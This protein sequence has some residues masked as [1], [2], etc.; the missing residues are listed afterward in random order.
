MLK[1]TL[2]R[3]LYGVLTLLIIITITFF[4]L[5]I[6]PGSPFNDEKLTA[7]QIAILN[8]KYGLSD[9][10]PMQY[11]RYIK[12]IVTKFDF[13]KSFKYDNQDV[14]RKLIVPRLPRTIKVGLFA[15]AIGITV[16]IILGSLA[17]L[18]RGNF[19]DNILIVLAVLGSSIPSFVFAMVLQYTFAVKIPIFPVLYD[20]TKIISIVLPAI[21]LSVSTISTLTRF[22]RTELVEVLNSDYILLAR[23][24]GLTNAQV[25]FKHALRNALIPVITIVGPMVLGILTGGVVMDTIFGIPGLG[26]LMVDGITLNDYFIVLTVATF[27]SFLFISVVLIIDLLY[28]VIDPRIRL[29][30][31]K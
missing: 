24:K 31:G 29:A 8:E 27:Y 9:P 1:Y 14:L 20:D 3:F 7:D 28:G 26:Q 17:A 18:N 16:G 11:F 25:I 21:A 22:V 13:G 10:L 15:L 2:E 19:V 5:K 23:A 4:L 30:G 6:L 12:N